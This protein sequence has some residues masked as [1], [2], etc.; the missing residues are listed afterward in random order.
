MGAKQAMNSE[1]SGISLHLDPLAPSVLEGLVIMAAALVFGLTLE[2]LSTA[3]EQKQSLVFRWS[4]N[5]SL[6]VIAY[7]FRW[8]FSAVFLVFVAAYIERSGLQAWV[9]LSALPLV[10]SVLSLF[11]IM[12]AVDYWV[13]R[14]MHR[15]PMLWQ[16]HSVHHSDPEVDAST[17]VRHHP[18][19]A[20]VALPPALIVLWLLGPPVEALL[21]YQVLRVPL[22]AFNHSNICLPAICERILVRV[23]VTPAFHRVHHCAQ[24]PY[25]NS[26][27]GTVV[28]WFDYL[29]GTATKNHPQGENYPLGLAA[30]SGAQRLDQLLLWPFRPH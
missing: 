28:P 20:L 15:V 2:L 3:R 17:S 27:F 24:L 5:L 1:H 4:N 19:E 29:F 23:L 10:L 18:L 14:L 11:L 12:E 6:A 26:N 7:Y 25:T 16:F 21:I 22:V 8:L 30:A 13:H 9:P